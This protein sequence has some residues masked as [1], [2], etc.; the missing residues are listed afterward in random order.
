MTFVFKNLLLSIS[1]LFLFVACSDKIN[2]LRY[3]KNSSE[4]I[5]SIP[6]TKKIDFNRENQNEISVIVTYLNSIDKEY[7]SKEIESFLVAIQNFN[8]VNLF[9]ENIKLL[10]NSKQPISFEKIEKDSS[11]IKNISLK[12]HWA[13]YYLVK[14]KAENK[15]K[16]LNFKVINKKLGIKTIVFEK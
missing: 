12:N 7:Q 11:L 16:K 2:A 3:F 6:N 15:V 13:D 1:I 4:T 10:L 9:K 14:F 8:S 5:N